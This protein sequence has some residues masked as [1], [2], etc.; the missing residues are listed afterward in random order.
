[1]IEAAPSADARALAARVLAAVLDGTALDQALLKADTQLHDPRDRA[2]VRA[3]VYAALR[4]IYH[5]NARL[6]QLLSQPL[7]ALDRLIHALL[8][9][10]LAQLEAALTP[11]Y[12]AVSGTVAAARALGRDKLSG[13]VNAVLRRHQR[14]A[15][16]ASSAS[17]APSD[18]VAFDHPQWLVDAL[19]RQFPAD[20]RAIVDA[21]NAPAPLWLRVNRR[22]SD[23]D[24]YGA[25]LREAGIEAQPD[26]ALPDAL[27]IAETL[28]AT[29]LAG[30]AEGDVSVQDA[31]AQ[32]A[33]E[34]LALKPGLRMLDACAAPG[35]KTAHIL[36][37]E[38]RL[39]QVLALDVR[40]PRVDLIKQTLKRLKLGATVREADATKPERWWDGRPFDRILIDAP[41]SGTGVIRRHPDIRLLRRPEDIAALALK[42]DALLDALWPMLAPGGR[43]VYATC[44]VLSEEND[45]R[46]AAFL[47]RTHDAEPAREVPGARFG[48]VRGAGWQNLPGEHHA[49][50]FFYAALEKPRG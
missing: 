49:D 35:G 14:E 22:R 42:Q 36:E 26:P 13:L 33:V 34:W 10:G 1:M 28:D 50:G 19:R 46:I 7:S 18:E 5:L 8:L 25:R 45:A 29:G 3:I 6:G 23:R 11:T 20:W 41:C 44:S 43:L 17:A 47:A 31:A 37:R 40:R 15:A 27:R 38:P 21:N 4:G 16:N 48:R 9:C 24:A 30:F 2:L 32:W 39:D 12:A